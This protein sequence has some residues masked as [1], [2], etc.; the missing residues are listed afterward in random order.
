MK[1]ITKVIEHLRSGKAAGVN[2]IQPELWKEGGPALHSKKVLVGSLFNLRRLH[3]HTKTLEQ[4]FLDLCI[5]DVA[6]IAHTERA[7]QHLTFCF[8]E[9]A[10]LFELEVRLK[11]TEILL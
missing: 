8:A 6:L 3:A 1:E 4:Q 7:R 9:A 10:Q 11:K 2:R 5:D